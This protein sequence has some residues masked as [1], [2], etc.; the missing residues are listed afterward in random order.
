MARALLPAFLTLPVTLILDRVPH[1]SRV[2]CA[3]NG[4]FAFAVLVF[5]ACLGL[6][7]YRSQ[8]LAG[9]G[10]TLSFG[11]L[12]VQ[13]GSPLFNPLFQFDV[14]GAELGAGVFADFD[15]TPAR[16]AFDS[17]KLGSTQPLTLPLP[18]LYCSHNP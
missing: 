2:L 5:D 8:A 1:S 12:Q 18:R 17:P 6:V 15:L 11:D 10:G 7:D 16:L 13:R 14:E 4:D 9:F 3:R